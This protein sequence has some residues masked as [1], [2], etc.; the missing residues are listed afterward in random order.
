M[1]VAEARASDLYL[2]YTSWCEGAG[3]ARG[4]AEEFRPAAHGER[5]RAVPQ[6]RD[7]VPG[8]EATRY[9]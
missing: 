4:V 9:E 1:R 6:Q 3:G 7:L 8:R 2:A 5:L